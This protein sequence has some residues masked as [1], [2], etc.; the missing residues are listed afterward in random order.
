MPAH[1]QHWAEL[2]QSIADG[3][4]VLVLGPDAI[5]LYRLGP[6]P[7]NDPDEAA[8]ATFNQLSRRRIRRALGEGV[9]YFYERDN[10]FLFRDW[11]AILTFSAQ[12]T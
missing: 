4:A 3:E 7:E 9:T 8:E 12:L 5:P 1:N 11:N 2:A 6:T 10:L